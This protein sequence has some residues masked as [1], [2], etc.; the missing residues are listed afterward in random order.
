[1]KFGVLQIFQN[2]ESADPDSLVWEQETAMA[3]AA[4][5]LGFDSVWV[6]EHHFR[7]YAA[8]PDNFQYLTW[9]AAQTKRIRLAT[10]AVILPWN[11]PLRVAEKLSVLD[12][13]S[14]GRAIFGMGRGLARCE[15]QG[16]GIEMDTSRGRFDEAA[17]CVLASLD[18]G[19]F[20]SA[21]PW[22][23]RT[24]TPIRPRPR[25]GFRDRVWCIAMSPDSVE[26][27]ARIGAGMAMFSQAA[28]DAASEQIERYRTLFREQHAEM[29]VPPVVTADMIVCDDDPDRAREMARKHIGAY[30]VTV[31][32]HY[33]LMSDHLKQARGYD[34]YGNAVDMLRAIGLERVVDSYI[35]VQ[36]WGT[37]EM[38]VEKLQQ[39]GEKIGDYQFNACFRFAGLPFDYAQRGMKLFADQ[40]IPRL[41]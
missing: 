27:A 19:I 33:E 23:T 36:A 3:L 17:D 29:A 12:Q 2:Y 31:F 11:D 13:L 30:L 24:P 8:C 38:I 1:M 9:L 28:W 39:R 35:D 21:G 14:G 34:M 4:D 32:Q 20:E 22:Y 37:P 7:D 16:F 26:A 10:G 41:I 40:V 6:V 15:Y 25:A 5:E 18:S